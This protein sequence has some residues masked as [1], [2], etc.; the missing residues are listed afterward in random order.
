MLYDDNQKFIEPK[1]TMSAPEGDVINNK[2]NAEITTIL[3][4]LRVQYTFIHTL[5]VHY[6]FSLFNCFRNSE[7]NVKDSFGYETQ[8]T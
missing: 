1:Q 5:H 6:N 7:Q 8:Y 3:G 4:I 2:N